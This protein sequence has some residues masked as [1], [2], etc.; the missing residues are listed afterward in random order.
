LAITPDGQRAYLSNRSAR[1]VEVIAILP[2]H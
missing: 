1:T 2:T